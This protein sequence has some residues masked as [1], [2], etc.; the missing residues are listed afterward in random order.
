MTRDLFS[1]RRVHLLRHLPIDKEAGNAV[2][3]ALSAANH[4]VLCVSNW[5]E[6]SSVEFVFGRSDVDDEG[7]DRCCTSILQLAAKGDPTESSCETA[8]RSCIGANGLVIRR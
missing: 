6:G 1:P 2:G 7:P 4:W 8:V 5:N 3:D